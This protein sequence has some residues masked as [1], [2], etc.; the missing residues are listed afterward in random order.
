MPASKSSLYCPGIGLREGG[1]GE[2]GGRE[3]EKVRERRRERR[4][5][6]GDLRKSVR[7]YD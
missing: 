1:G 3:G 2:N 4:D 5:R 6:V 7:R